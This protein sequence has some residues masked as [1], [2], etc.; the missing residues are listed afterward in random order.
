MT[1]TFSQARPLKP[2]EVNP[3][4]N[5]VS[6]ALQGYGQGMQAAYLPQTIQASIFNKTISPLATLAAS[7]FFSA[8]NPMQQHQIADYI[9][10]SLEGLGVFNQGGNAKAPNGGITQHAQQGNGVPQERPGDFNPPPNP[11]EIEEGLAP[12]E[13]GEHFTSKFGESSYKP[14]TV[15]K[16]KSGNVVSTPTGTQVERQQAILSGTTKLGKLYEEYI[17]LGK[18][19]ADAGIVRT[20]LSRLAGGA[21]KIAGK[22][23][24]KFLGGRGLAEKAAKFEDLK[25]KLK[26]GLKETNTISQDELDRQLDFRGGESGKAFEKRSR[27]TINYLNK[28][29]SSG[30]NIL[31]TGFNVSSKLPAIPTVKSSEKKGGTSEHIKK[32]M[33]NVIEAA[34]RFHTTPEVVMAAQKA[35]VKSANDFREWIRTHANEK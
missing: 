16:T 28:L 32:Y 17:T 1:F 26:Q 35:G 13:P 14:G 11:D 15:H 27:E 23:V 7:P 10:R 30:K 5:L 2:Q 22:G 34:N 3:F 25:G 20:D 4:A 21:G 33:N 18:E 12:G 19:L 9:S 6:N 8:L 24:E 29:A 31:S